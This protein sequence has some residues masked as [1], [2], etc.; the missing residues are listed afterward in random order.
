V[1]L[2]K[3]G[4]KE[5]GEK[6]GRRGEKAAHAMHEIFLIQNCTYLQKIKKNSF[7]LVCK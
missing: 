4:K 2:K 6:G 3:R 7:V 1:S 5:E